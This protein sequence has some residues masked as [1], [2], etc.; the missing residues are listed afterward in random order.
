MKNILVVM[1]ACFVAKAF[2]AELQHGS[3]ESLPV[4]SVL[5]GIPELNSSSTQLAVD[6]V[7]ARCMLNQSTGALA[8]EPLV[9]D[10]S[11]LK[12]QFKLIGYRKVA[13][14]LIHQIGRNAIG[15]GSQAMLA[16]F[17]A[18]GLFGLY[19][20]KPLVHFNGDDEELLKKYP[21]DE[22]MAMEHFT[23]ALLPVPNLLA[24]PA[25]VPELAIDG[26]IDVRNQPKWVARLKFGLSAGTRMAVFFFVWGAGSS[27]AKDLIKHFFGS[28]INIPIKLVFERR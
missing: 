15:V 16:G 24:W 22:F 20:S 26:L 17:I 8:C 23:Y 6:Q 12:D 28:G 5:A 10:L 13:S 9:G 19:Y 25:G 11:G 21:R 27:I 4:L 7:S 2:A 18:G 3:R 14:A 1:M